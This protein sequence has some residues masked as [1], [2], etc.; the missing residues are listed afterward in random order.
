MWWHVTYITL[1]LRIASS[2]VHAR[3]SVSLCERTMS[4]KF[5]TLAHGW[6]VPLSLYPAD[7]VI[8]FFSCVL[9]SFH[10]N[11][12]AHEAVSEFLDR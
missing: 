11:H 7:T 5:L 8:V 4:C 3:R 10:V 2:S 1:R 6:S 12:L 9:I